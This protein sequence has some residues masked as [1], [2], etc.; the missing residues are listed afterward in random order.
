[1][2]SVKEQPMRFRKWFSGGFAL[3]FSSCLFTIGCPAWAQGDQAPRVAAI[4]AGTAAA[5][6]RMGKTLLADAFSFRSHTIRAYVGPNGELLH[7][8]H[9]SKFVIRRP[10][11]LLTE[12]TGDDGSTSMLYDGS[13]F[14]IYRPEQKKYLSIAVTGHLESMLAVVEERVGV[15]FPLEDLLSDNPSAALPSGVTTGG[16]VGTAMIDGVRCRHFYFVQSPDLDMEL[17][18]ED[19]NRAVP[20]RLFVTYNLLPGRPTFSAELSEWDFSA[21]PSDA[22]FVFRP[23]PGTEEV[24][25]KPKAAAP[26]GREK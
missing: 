14:V 18:L 20:R 8:A 6:D 21:H 26:S 9:T 19:N 22:D 5:L 17:W 16:A 25:V 10:D 12:V 24:A 7:I 11:K 13:K 23:P 1:M 2:F 15:D 4:D 3:I